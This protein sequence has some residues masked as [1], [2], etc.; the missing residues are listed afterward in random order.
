VGVQAVCEINVFRPKA[1]AQFVAGDQF[2]WTLQQKSENGD[3]LALQ[4]KLGAVLVQLGHMAVE[5]EG[6]ETDLLLRGWDLHL[7]PTIAATPAFTQHL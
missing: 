6:S 5:L 7:Y 4:L 2:P 3:G 1:L